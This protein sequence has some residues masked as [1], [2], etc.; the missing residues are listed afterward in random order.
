M[1]EMHLRQPGF[2]F[3]AFGP[4]TK[5][6]IRIQKFKETRD[7]KCIYQNELDKSCF[8]NNMV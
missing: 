5:E 8:Q 1:P 4:F 2:T 3:S 6:K 7:S